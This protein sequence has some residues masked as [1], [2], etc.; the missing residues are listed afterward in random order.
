MN[1]V[2]RDGRGESVSRSVDVEPEEA[3]VGD[4]TRDVLAPD[5][6]PNLENHRRIPLIILK[7]SVK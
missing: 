2:S 5:T 3:E 6:T 7:N 1:G 4:A